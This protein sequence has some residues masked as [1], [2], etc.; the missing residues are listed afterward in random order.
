MNVKTVRANVKGPMCS[1]R[2]Y[3]E[4]VR[5]L[6]SSRQRLDG[7]HGLPPEG[8]NLY[9]GTLASSPIPNPERRLRSFQVGRS[10]A[11]LTPVRD[12][13]K[14]RPACCYSEMNRSAPSPG[15]PLLPGGGSPP[16]LALAGPASAQEILH[17]TPTLTF[18]PSPLTTELATTPA[19]TS[20]VVRPAPRCRDR[21]EPSLSGDHGREAAGRR[22]GDLRQFLNDDRARRRSR[23]W[24]ATIAERLS[25]REREAE[26]LIPELEN[27]SRSPRRS[28]GYS[29][30][31]RTS[32]SRAAPSQRAR[33][34]RDAVR[35][36]IGAAATGGGRPRPRPRRDPRPADPRHRHQAR[37]RRRPST[38]RASSSPSSSSRRA[39]PEPKTR[40]SRRWRPETSG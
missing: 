29:E 21:V 38:R 14:R 40:S 3:S 6:K 10:K 32:T 4:S 11:K 31:G 7:R 36:A 19:E 8:G 37:R 25:G 35:S 24:T 27:R 22:R 28:R 26:G 13:H 23:L 9:S 18:R 34:T 17:R 16:A 5:A 20:G 2:A 39:T 30:R 12:R 1:R 33:L 15:P